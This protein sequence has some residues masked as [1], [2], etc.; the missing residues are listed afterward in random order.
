[1]ENYAFEETVNEDTGKSTK[2]KV[3]ELSESAKVC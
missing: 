2:R 1:M 3:R